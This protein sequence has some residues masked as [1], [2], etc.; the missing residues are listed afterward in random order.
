MKQRITPEQYRRYTHSLWHTADAKTDDSDKVFGFVLAHA[1]LVLHPSS[2]V[3]IEDLTEEL[4]QAT[5]LTLAPCSSV[6]FT[7]IYIGVEAAREVLLA[8]L[9]L[10]PD[11]LNIESGEGKMLAEF[12]EAHLGKKGEY[13]QIE[14]DQIDSVVNLLADQYSRAENDSTVHFVDGEGNMSFRTKL[15]SKTIDRMVDEAAGL[16]GDVESQVGKWA[17]GLG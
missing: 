5:G 2:W 7:H 1:W 11:L 3:E 8:A 16:L 13:S 6:L 9:P 4:K 10:P 12:V 15:G 17:E 14:R